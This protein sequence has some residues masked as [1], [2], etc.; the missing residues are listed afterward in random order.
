MGKLYESLDD[1][2]SFLEQQHLFF[3]ATAPSAAVATGAATFAASRA[4]SAAATGPFATSV[5]FTAGRIALTLCTLTRPRAAR[6]LGAVA[7]GASRRLTSCA[8]M[9]FRCSA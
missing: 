9:G 5:G 2:R 6:C 7:T 3:V 4:V 1:V 8:T